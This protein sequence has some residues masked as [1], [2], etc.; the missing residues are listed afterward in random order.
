LAL[1]GELRREGWHV[2][3]ILNAYWEPLTFELPKLRGGEPWRLWID[4][5]RESPH[6]IVPWQDAP[7]VSDGTYRADARSVVMLFTSTETEA[8]PSLSDGPGS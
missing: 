3:L 6:D 1:E 5:A 4:T 8:G 7:T 2:H